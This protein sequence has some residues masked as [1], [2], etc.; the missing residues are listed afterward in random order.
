V[1]VN[2]LLIP[3]NPFQK[4][5]SG[6]LWYL[7]V[8]GPGPPKW[9]L[10][11]ASLYR[12]ALL[13]TWRTSGTTRATV[14]LDLLNCLDVQSTP[15]VSDPSVASDVGA[16]AWSWDRE[17]VSRSVEDIYPMHLQFDDGVERIATSILIDRVTWVGMI[18]CVIWCTRFN[19][20]TEYLQ[21]VLAFE[22]AETR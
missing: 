1:I 19:C 9:I 15:T 21:R 12:N 11:N 18:L 2:F 3:L 6:F 16:I 14:T 8:H 13:L 5:Y 20:L 17:Q 7:N 22:R 10:C 4:L